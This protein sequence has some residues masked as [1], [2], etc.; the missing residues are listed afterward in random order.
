MAEA[1]ANHYGADVLQASS[2]GLSPTGHVARDTVRVMAEKNVDVSAHVPR[3]FDP[4][5]TS[6]Y[7]I[8][9]NLS[10]IRLPNIPADNLLTWK[11]ADPYNSPIE[12][13]QAARDELER[14]VMKLILDLRAQS[15]PRKKRPGLK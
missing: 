12:K 2:A 1:F 6:K 13:Y 11:V 5:E 9:V 15:A 14:L 4:R 3:L 10:G 7:D 8:V